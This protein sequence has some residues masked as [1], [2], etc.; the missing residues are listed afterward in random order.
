MAASPPRDPRLDRQ[1]ETDVRPL[2]ATES[3]GLPGWLI[4]LGFVLLAVV[5]FVILDGR[6][7][8]G[9]APPVRARIADDEVATRQAP[10]LFVPPAPIVIAPTPVPT[11]T[12]TPQPTFPPPR[13]PVYAPPPPAP[14]IVYVPQPA[15]PP[16]ALPP[17]PRAS[18]DPVLVIDNGAGVAPA[19]ATPDTATAQSAPA[20]A[21]VMRNR[22]TTISQGT[23]IPAVLESA[24]DSTR[25]GP[26]RGLV[27]RDVRG[28]DGSIVL[29]PRG[30]R[31]FGDYRADLQPGQNRALVTWTRLVRPDG[32]TIA[33]AS[34]ASDPLGR[35]GIRGS[36]NS[37]FLE[38][39]AA[40]ILQSTLDIG[41]GYASRLNTSNSAVVVALPN[42]AQ[43]LSQ[44][45]TEGTRRIQPTLRVR[46]GTAIDVFVARD[47]DFT[48]VERRR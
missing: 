37:H 26:V 9:T 17:Q 16:L 32:A 47:L 34:P 39:F 42:T 45:L 5:L 36:V 3:K 18:N 19:V 22:R 27:S 13:P 25:A 40:A 24:L 7:R 21:S 44:P 28:F 8:A 43:T 11:P 23:L 4:V 2:V 12:P 20:R 35:A 33:L 41:V 38:R 46:Q 15:P 31:L 48:A 1:G 30:S 29:V 14:Q 6:R 10:P